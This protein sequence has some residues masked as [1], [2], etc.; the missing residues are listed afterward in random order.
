[1][2][3]A[4]GGAKRYEQRVVVPTFPGRFLFVIGVTGGMSSAAIV[5]TALGDDDAA[6]EVT[7][8]WA[9]RVA[10]GIGMRVRIEGAEHVDRARPQVFM[11][12][13]QSHVDI[14]ALLA[15]LPVLPGFLAKKELRD[16]PLF[17]RAMDSGGHVFIDRQNRREAFAAIEAAA[18]QV[19][20]GRNIVVFPEGTR[21]APGTVKRFKRGGFHLAQQSG[22]PIVPVGIRGTAD[23]LKKHSKRIYPGAV[24]LHV[25]EPLSSELVASLQIPELVSEVRGRIAQLAGMTLVD[26]R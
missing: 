23:V 14:I 21:S 24:A 22:V 1:V 16:V 2:N 5:R 26:E 18:V 19:R 10:R 12:N 6:A 25:G 15:G 4:N 9:R 13:H 8:R 7:P 20:R 11:C 3:D 17:G